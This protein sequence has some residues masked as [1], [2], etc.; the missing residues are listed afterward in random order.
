M[1]PNTGDPLAGLAAA[2][3]WAAGAQAVGAALSG[4]T[5]SASNETG[6]VGSGVAFNVGAPR[7]SIPQAGGLP[8]PVLL[9]GAAV[10]GAVVLAALK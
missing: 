3:P 4:G 5:S 7:H 8:L 9:A 2:N 10:A 1:G 6:S